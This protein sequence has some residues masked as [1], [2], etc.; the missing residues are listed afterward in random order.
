MNDSPFLLVKIECPV[1]KTLNEFE[2]VKV[3]AYIEGG[4]DSDGHSRAVEMTSE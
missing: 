2:S 4:R 3:G 1:C